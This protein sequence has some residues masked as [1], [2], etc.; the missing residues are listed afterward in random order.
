MKFC[1][2]CGEAVESRIPDGDNRPRFVCPACDVIHY[3]NPRIV[4]GCL[5]E[6]DGQLLLCS[7]AIEPRHG[8][9]TPPAGFM[10]NGESVGQAAS[11]E[12]LEEANARVDNLRLFAMYS[13][14][15]INQVH[16]F[17]RARLMDTDFSAGIESLDVGLFKEADVPWDDLAFRVTTLALRDYYRDPDATHVDSIII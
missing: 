15:H 9:W 12:T 6:W 13:I 7:R 17:F 8:F 4:A 14:P 5:P 1:S 10:E 2:S 3:Q 16:V 11:R